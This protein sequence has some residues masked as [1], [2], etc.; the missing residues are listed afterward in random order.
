MKILRERKEG[1]F[2][3]L[4][5][6]LCGQLNDSRG[7]TGI[8]YPTLDDAELAFMRELENCANAERDQAVF[9]NLNTT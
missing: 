4:L 9:A 5:D 3:A 7:I 1:C 8:N 6:W 2:N